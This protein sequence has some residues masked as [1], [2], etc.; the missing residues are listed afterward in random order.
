VD[1][2][3]VATKLVKLPP[4]VYIESTYITTNGFGEI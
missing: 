4:N 3:D 2:L 1:V